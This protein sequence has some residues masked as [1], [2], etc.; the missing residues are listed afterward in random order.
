MAREP[1]APYNVVAVFRDLDTA[2]QAVQDLASE[3]IERERISLQ[4][5]RL[6]GEEPTDDSVPVVEPT[7]RRRDREV[8]GRVFKRAMVTMTV[9]TVLIGVV[10][11]AVGWAIFGLW[12]LGMWI[13]VAVGVFMGSVLGAVQGGAFGAMEEGRKEEGVLVGAHFDD[14]ADMERAA[15][16]MR[17]KGPLRVDF[18]D[19]E[20]GVPRGG[21]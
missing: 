1:Y 2:R 20:G 14:A 8:L 10:A 6:T 4:S 18:Y 3:G 19:A 11:F 17:A 5:R 16:I 7:S 15:K 21:S 12:T 13:C 9:A